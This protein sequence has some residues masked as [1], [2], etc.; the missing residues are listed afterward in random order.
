[1]APLL[2]RVT[3]LQSTEINE[4][5]VLAGLGAVDLDAELWRA[6]TLMLMADPSQ[7][8]VLIVRTETGRACGLLHYR[9]VASAQ[10]RPSLEVQRLVAFALM[11][12]HRI[13]DRLI[14]EAIRRARLQA[15]DSLRL[16]RPLDSPA[17]ASALVLASGV[18][19]LHSV[20]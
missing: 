10:A 9:I 19:N 4:A 14:A 8:G 13:A 15:C 5:L 11:D 18:A 2:L 16:V 3:P 1:M 6:E 12:P 7:G 20:F 17:E